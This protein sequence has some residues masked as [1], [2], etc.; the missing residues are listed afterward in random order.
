MGAAVV[1]WGIISYLFS[2]SSESSSSNRKTMK[3]PGKD[4]RMYRDEFEKDA[5]AYFLNERKR[6]KG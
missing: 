2:D 4:E 5:A 3:A 6:R 1:G